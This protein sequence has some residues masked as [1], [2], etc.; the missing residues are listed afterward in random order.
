MLE[1]QSILL[2]VNSLFLVV[3]LSRKLL[4]QTSS[5]SRLEHNKAT[6]EVKAALK[7]GNLNHSPSDADSPYCFLFAVFI[8]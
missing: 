4:R 5:S 7:S 2:I 8:T 3:F 6:G 1:S